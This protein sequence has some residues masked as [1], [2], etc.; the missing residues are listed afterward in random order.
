M[1]RVRIVLVLAI[2]ATGLFYAGLFVVRPLLANVV[3]HMPENYE[4]LAQRA[5][6]RKDYD[7]AVEACRR[8]IARYEY[9]FLARFRLV[10]VLHHAGRTGE[11]LAQLWQMPD[12]YRAVRG[13]RNVPSR[14]WDEARVH[15][16]LAEALWDLGRFEESLDDL[17]AALDWRDP[18]IEQQ[19]QEFIARVRQMRGDEVAP[20]AF[21][22]GVIGKPDGRFDQVPEL[23]LFRRRKPPVNFYTRLAQIALGRKQDDV[24]RRM[25]DKELINHPRDLPSLLAHRW[26]FDQVPP[27]PNWRGVPRPL[28]FDTRVDHLTMGRITYPHESSSTLYAAHAVWAR[29]LKTSLIHGVARPWWTTQG[30]CIVARGKPCNG[31]WPILTIRFQGGI[32]G[33]AYVR[34][35]YFQ[36]YTIPFVVTKGDRFFDVGFE[37]D[38]VNRFTQEDRNVEIREIRLF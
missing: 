21:V 11:A 8:E 30:L 10:E 15:G 12:L 38:A 20:W 16:M 3:L 4:Y 17:Q 37:N 1:H 6:D 32:I 25:F 26:F 18:K 13:R 36:T 23:T 5:V 31:I 34:S 28:D 19:C 2:A 9:N 33:R 35:T 29:M 14:G 22:A 24:A 7:Q 27:P